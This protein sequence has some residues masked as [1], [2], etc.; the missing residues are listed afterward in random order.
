MPLFVLCIKEKVIITVLIIASP[1][2]KHVDLLISTYL[3]D[4]P[5]REPQPID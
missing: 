2:R 3:E 1:A 4:N 5:S